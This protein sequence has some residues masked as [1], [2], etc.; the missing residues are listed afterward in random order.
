MNLHRDCIVSA[1]LLLCT[2]FCTSASAELAPLPGGPQLQDCSKALDPTRCKARIEARK[3][4]GDKRGDS[5]R[6]CMATYLV[7]PDCSH[8]AQPKRCIAQ[9]KAEQACQG[10]PSK[11]VKAC[12]RA[13]RMT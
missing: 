10:K 5:K 9:K 4:C 1:L 12:L 8:A 2:V 7:A 11:Q 3:A 6:A 13:H